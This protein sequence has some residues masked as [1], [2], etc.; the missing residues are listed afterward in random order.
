ALVFLIVNNSNHLLLY[1][2][3]YASTFFLTGIF[4]HIYIRYF[5]GL[6]IKKIK[7]IQIKEYLIEGLPTFFTSIASSIYSGVGIT[8]LV[9]FSTDD[10]VGGYSAIFKI[11]G[12]IISLFSPILQA[13]F[14]LI[15]KY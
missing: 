6:E 8:I 4:S 2:F 12:I 14:P 1:S 5:I 11:P 9:I 13:L 10:I 15:S 3:L 7:F